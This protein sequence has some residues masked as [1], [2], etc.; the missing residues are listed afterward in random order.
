MLLRSIK[1]VVYFYCELSLLLSPHFITIVVAI[2][3]L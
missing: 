2:I 1:K 3:A